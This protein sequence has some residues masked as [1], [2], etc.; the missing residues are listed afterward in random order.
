[1][2]AIRFY[3]L[4]F[5]MFL[6]FSGCAP[7]P[8]KRSEADQKPEVYVSDLGGGYGLA[9][10]SSGVLYAAGKDG[11]KFVVWKITGQE[12]KEV[13]AVLDMHDPILS[14]LNASSGLTG[15]M[16]VDNLG[17]VWLTSALNGQCFAAAPGK[18]A[19]VV[20]VNKSITSLFDV[21]NSEGVA[22][23]PDN[24][25]LYIVTAGPDPSE[26]YSN[27]LVCHIS[28][29]RLS[30][31]NFADGV[32]VREN[33]WD[34]APLYIN[35]EGIELKYPGVGLI[36]GAGSGLYYIGSDQLY[37]V[38]DDVKP[39][40]KKFTGLALKGGAVDSAG[41]LYVSANAK[42]DP[43]STKGAIYKMDADRKVALL[44]KDVGKP[45]GLAWRDGYLYFVEGS[46]DRILRVKTGE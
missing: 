42:D 25:A 24:G 8:G 5:A 43:K 12:T 39:I 29:H 26:R 14:M 16:T 7:A 3:V 31:G 23:D 38:Q 21:E 20:Y 32:S 13:Y 27:K 17:T 9:F 11:G 18:D 46:G 22:Y 45:Y 44:L 6:V 4:M 2:K 30:T 19:R 36:K 10:D 28:S 34:P 40:G 37:E 1:M 15:N 41:T 33:G 35:N